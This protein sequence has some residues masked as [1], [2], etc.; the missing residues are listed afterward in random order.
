MPPEIPQFYSDGR[1][2][3]IRLLEFSLLPSFSDSI[4]LIL[5]LLHSGSNVLC[6]A[7]IP[8]WIEAYSQIATRIRFAAFSRCALPP[9]HVSDYTYA[10][11]QARLREAGPA[12]ETAFLLRA[13]TSRSYAI[14]SFSASTMQPIYLLS[15]RWLRRRTKASLSRLQVTQKGS[16]VCVVQIVR[17]TGNREQVVPALEVHRQLGVLKSTHYLLNSNW[18]R[19]RCS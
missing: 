2:N 17:R 16:R 10:L 5:F 12:A 19:R 3:T 4:T 13:S 6:I 7:F 9:L 18:V 15:R 1:P 14:H 11:R 8:W